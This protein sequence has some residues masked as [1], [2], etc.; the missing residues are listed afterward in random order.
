MKIMRSKSLGFRLIIIFVSVSVPL[1]IGLIVVS[2]FAKSTVLSQVALSYQ[3]LV[4]SN[5]QMLD[6]SLEDTGNNMY[7]LTT[8]NEDFL[9]LGMSNLSDSDYY[10]AQ[11]AFLDINRVYQSYFH[12]VDLFFIYSMSNDLLLT[13]D[14][15]GASSYF[16]ESIVNAIPQIM[17]N[18]DVP[19]TYLYAWKLIEINGESY[20]FRLSGDEMENKVYLGAL[21]HVNSLKAPLQNMNL[22]K[23]G[24]ILFVSKEGKVLTEQDSHPQLI[25]GICPK[26]SWRKA[27]R[28]T[29]HL[30]AKDCSL[31]INTRSVPALI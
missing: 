12:S 24:D 14:V 16:R 19:K 15:Q 29:F 27:S 10:F 30:T 3:N 9:K 8:H 31:S 20:L 28:F 13:T 21:I 5:I 11:N 4:D 25:Q 7:Y 23:S 17:K 26:L 6:K 22:G 1:L 2:N 18:E